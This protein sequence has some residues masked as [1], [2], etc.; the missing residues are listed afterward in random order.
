MFKNSYRNESHGRYRVA[1]ATKWSK[2][3]KIEKK[4]RLVVIMFPSVKGDFGKYAVRWQDRDG[5]TFGGGSDNSLES[6]HNSFLREYFDHN[7]SFRKGN[8]SHLP[9]LVK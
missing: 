2:G 7:A 1:H 4:L 9:G 3:D 5:N 8:P 6:A